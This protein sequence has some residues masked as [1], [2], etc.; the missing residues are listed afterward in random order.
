MHVISTKVAHPVII[1]GDFNTLDIN[2]PTLTGLSS[3]ASKL[4]DFIFDHNLSQLI[5]QPTHICSNILDLAITIQE[6]L[7]SSLTVNTLLSQSLST[8]HHPIMFD[9]MV[10]RRHHNKLK[11]RY[12]FNFSVMDIDLLHS[13]LTSTDLLISYNSTGVEVIWNTIK[14]AVLLGMD[15]SIPKIK[16]TD[17]HSPPLWFTS[18]VR[19]VK[20]KKLKIFN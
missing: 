20:Q 10:Q 8:D 14:S 2:W 5:D 9:I 7:I 17:D 4:V 19:L 6:Y 1:L 18:E 16:V 13:F 15:Q 3:N 12:V 11:S